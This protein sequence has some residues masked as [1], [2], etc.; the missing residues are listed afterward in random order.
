M[1]Y[2]SRFH[3][4]LHNNLPGSEYDQLPELLGCSAHRRTSLMKRPQDADH[5]ET[6]IFA[7]LLGKS[8]VFLM[9]G[10]QLGV[11]GLTEAEKEFHRELEQHPVRA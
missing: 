3:E 11:R 1:K 8:V 6:L 4:Y 5:T 7:R 9:D 2:E 10:Y